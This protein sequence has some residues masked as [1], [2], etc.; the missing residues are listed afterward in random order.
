[1]IVGGADTEVLQLNRAAARLLRCPHEVVVVPGASHLFEEP[2]ALDAVAR[3]AS[4][5]FAQHLGASSLTTAT[6]PEVDL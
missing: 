3:L 5:W 4:R 1:M 6:R 2:G